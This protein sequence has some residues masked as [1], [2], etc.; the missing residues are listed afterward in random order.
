[1]KPINSKYDLAV[2]VALSRSLRHLVVTSDEAAEI[3]NEFLREKQ[4]SKDVLILANV[5]DR[6]LSSGIHAKI[7]DFGGSDKASLIYDVIE[8]SKVDS[9]IEKAVRFFCGDKVVTETFE[10]ASMLQK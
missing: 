2:K 1:M 7:E 6:Q 10:H 3:C 8:V 5:P 4:I 9:R